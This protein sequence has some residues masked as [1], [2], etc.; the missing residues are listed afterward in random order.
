MKIIIEG[1]DGAGK[2]TLANYLSEKL[3]FPV[4]HRTQPKSEEEKAKM[5]AQYL[6]DA[7]E[8]SNV[9]YDRF[10]YSEIVYGTIMRDASVISIAQMYEV[11]EHLSKSGGI[12][13]FCDNNTENLWKEC[14]KRGETYILDFD[15]LNSI[16]FAYR[17]L[18]CCKSHSIP[19]LHYRIK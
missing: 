4:V 15:T 6:Y 1:P 10:L 5:F 9:I 8:P 7:K 19:V 12:I 11:E 2:T 13:I 17:D 16:A 3:G 18:I 14:L